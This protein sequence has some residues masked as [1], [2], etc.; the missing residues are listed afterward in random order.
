MS[1]ATKESHF[2]HLHFNAKA[3]FKSGKKREGGKEGGKGKI[4]IKCA[5][6]TA[7]VTY[8]LI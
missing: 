4:V 8:T 3:Q 1:Q 2:I 7:N 6:P 5:L